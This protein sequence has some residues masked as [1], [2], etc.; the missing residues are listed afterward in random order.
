MKKMKLIATISLLIVAFNSASFGQTATPAAVKYN[1]WS[2][3]ISAGQSLFYGDIRQFDFYP[4]SKKYM[5]DRKYVVK[6]EF[7]DST[8]STSPLLKDGISERNF[9]YGI[10]VT[11]FFTN[12]FALQGQFQAGKLSGVRTKI[13]RYFQAVYKAYGINGIINLGNLFVPYKKDHKFEVYGLIGY[14]F[15][16]FKTRIKTISTD[17]MIH[18]YGYGDFNQGSGKTPSGNKT[19][20]NDKNRT[21]EQAVPIGLGIK[22]KIN[23]HFDIGIESQMVNVNTDKL[24]SRIVPLSEKD[25]YG[26]TSVALTYKIGKNEKALEWV[27]MA[28][29]KSD[30]LA[31]LFAA[32]NRKIDSLGNKLKDVDAR[33][34]QV[35]KD[36]TDLK[37]PVKEAD[38]DNDGVPNSKDLEANTPAGTLVDVNGRE[39]KLTPGS[40]IEAKPYISVFFAVDKITIDALNEERIASVAEMLKGDPNLKFTLIGHADKTGGPEYNKKLSERRAQAVKDKLINSYGIDASRLFT[41]GKGIL[42]PLSI[43]ILSVNRR[44]DFVIKK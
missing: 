25:K 21:S 42:E 2:A 15:V 29:M 43:D 24:D 23:S 16:D 12:T 19:D 27:S 7:R 8:Y 14:S 18:S 38:D 36:V 44:V 9:G 13:D 30:D 11:K 28:D 17:S 10:A 34:G 5:A 20:K 41:E 4:L 40:S 3:T 32:I 35:Q 1:T 22:Y 33:L 37:N 26:Y 6:N 39:I 31:P